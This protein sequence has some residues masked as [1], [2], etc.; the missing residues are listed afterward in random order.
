MMQK[1]WLFSSTFTLTGLDG[2]TV[3]LNQ[4]LLCVLSVFSMAL[5][6]FLIFLETAMDFTLNLP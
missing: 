1:L 3:L 4:M 2:Q 6:F 5:L